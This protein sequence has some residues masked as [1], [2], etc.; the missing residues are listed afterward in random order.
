[1]P[2]ALCG[3]IIPSE[4]DRCPACGAWTRRRNFRALGLAVFLLLG[5]NAFMALGSGVG[6]ARMFGPLTSDTVDTYD[7]TATAHTLAAYADVFTV[8]GV[9]AALTGVL[10]LAWLWRAHRQAGAARRY[11]PGW[12]VA[13]WL[14]PV[15]NLWLPPRLVHDV[16]VGSAPHR[17][18]DRQRA[19]AVVMTW[20]ITLLGAVGLAQLFRTAG[21]ESLADA[22]LAAQI[23][24]AGAAAQ[25]LA[26]VL[27]MVIVFHITRLQF[28]KTQ[29]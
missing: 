14:F 17:P 5:F 11:R 10:F 29:A 12:V 4:V 8:A 13:G 26:A 21:M 19:G 22:R 18:I 7:A 15:V 27:C 6:L 9:L 16:W 3:D 1:M 20:W 24:L 25:A 23:G 28:A 2:C